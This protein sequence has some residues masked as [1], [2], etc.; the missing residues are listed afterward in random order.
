[1]CEA[2]ALQHIRAQ[3][4][5]KSRQGERT[6]QGLQR[7]GESLRRK[8]N[9]GG[10]PHRQHHQ[11][12]HAGYGLDRADR[13][14][15]RSPNAEKVTEPRTLSAARPASEP[16]TGTPNTSHAEAHQQSN[17]DYQQHQS[18]SRNDSK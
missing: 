4:I 16:R 5:D 15:T 14:A 3:R 10:D 12:R 11:V 17:L 9:A 2:A 6:D 18:E 8:E 7:I 1:M 13:L